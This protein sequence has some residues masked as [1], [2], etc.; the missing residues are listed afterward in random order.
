MK[1]LKPQILSA[2]EKCCES[3]TFP[4]LDN[5][6][7]YSAASRLALYRSA[8]D[9]A[10]TIEVFGF[11][12]RSGIPDTQVYTFGSRLLRQK[13]K[14]DFVSAEAY[15]AYLANNP[16][17]ESVF[18]YPVDEG[19]WQDQD[20]SELVAEEA[21]TVTIRGKSL[22]IPSREM[23]ATHGISL[24][25]ESRVHVFE[26]CRL[27]AAM[28]RECVLATNEERRMCV[29]PELE[30]ILQLEEWH[31]PD[32]AGGSELSSSNTFVSLADVL[33]NGDVALYK[34]TMP[35]NSYWRNWPEAGTL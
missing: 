8:E 34:I 24:E 5:G 4:M 16:N 6:Y 33:V 26:L 17:N 15:A 29:P 30:Q 21:Q 27:L 18:V 7:V 1:W 12:P 2:L 35:A 32:L 13:G 19:D 3:F 31:H 11:S 14:A 10:M 9:W 22:P 20:D 25:D 23:Y 28:N